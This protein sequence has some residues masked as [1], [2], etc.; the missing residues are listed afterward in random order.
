MPRHR[1]A[2]PVLTAGAAAPRR[3]SDPVSTADTLRMG[4]PIL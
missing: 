2:H 1:V 4:Q 3:A